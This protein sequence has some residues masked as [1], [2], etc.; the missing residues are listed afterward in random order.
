[1]T[2]D[3][4]RNGEGRHA[5]SIIPP[6]GLSG[7]LN[8]GAAHLPPVLVHG[9]GQC[10]AR[11]TG[12]DAHG[13]LHSLFPV[14]AIQESVQHL[15]GQR[16]DAWVLV[17]VSQVLPGLRAGGSCPT[18]Y[19]SPSP[20]TVTMPSHSLRLSPWTSSRAWF[21]RSNV[22]NQEVRQAIPPQPHQHFPGLRNPS[23]PSTQTLPLPV[24]MRLKDSPA[25]EIM[26]NTWF[27]HHCQ[28]R[29]RPPKG[30]TS[31]S[32]RGGLGRS[33][34]VI[35]AK[36]REGVYRGQQPGPLIS[37]TVTANSRRA[38]TR[39]SWELSFF[40]PRPQLSPRC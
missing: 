13:R 11:A 20:E 40:P 37:E 26:G 29:P 24:W 21:C 38:G 17:L 22:E 28:A 35:S 19:S 36:R 12:E 33:W 4:Q 30:L 27:L 10:I 18:S 9:S 23:S 34:E 25:S 32:N 2:V 39:A 5:R 8:T 7:S 14:R 31:R 16:P 1:M 6:S 15:E 3:W